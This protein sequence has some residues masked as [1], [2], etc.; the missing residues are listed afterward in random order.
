MSSSNTSL[1][2]HV[3]GTVDETTTLPKQAVR[4]AIAEG[5]ISRSQL[6]WSPGHNAW[7]QVRELPHLLPSQ[8]LAPPPTPRV[9]SGKLPRMA[10]G[11]LP[12][13]ASDSV[14]RV[15]TGT[16]PR[17]ATGPIPRVT[18][19]T[20]KPKAETAIQEKAPN[21]DVIEKSHINPLKWLCLI[22]GVLILGAVGFNY[23]VVEQPLLSALSQTPYSKVTVYAHL[24]GFVQ[25][26]AL[27]I[28]IM[29]SHLL[30]KSN[31]TDFL[32]ALAHST[33]QNTGVFERISLTSG[34]S[35]QYSISGSDWKEFGDMAQASEDQRKEFLLNQLGATDG[36]PLVSLNSTMT[37]EAQRAEQEKIWAAFV[38]QLTHS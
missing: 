19:S 33:P 36:R 35:S 34:F 5:K 16:L 6:I 8:Q 28:H 7:K 21:Y 9:A 2:L 37:A 27:V 1:I 20:E 15:A 23:L 30:N 4:A 12:R 10:T 11:A 18:I 14:P 26:N 31:L 17:V 29:G 38:A 3:K 32:V 13:V 24:G 25:K 22:L